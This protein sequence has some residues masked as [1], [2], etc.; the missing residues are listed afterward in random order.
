MVIQTS[1]PGRHFLRNEPSKVVASRKTTI[2]VIIIKF[3]LSRK[4]NKKK[5]TI[6]DN[7]DWPP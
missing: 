2:F 6:F 3:I 4:Q 7:L 1:V 5:R